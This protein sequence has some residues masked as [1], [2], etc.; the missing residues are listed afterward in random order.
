M[1]TEKNPKQPILEATP[2]LAG[3]QEIPEV[4]EALWHSNS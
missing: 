2:S 4:L 1:G 3:K